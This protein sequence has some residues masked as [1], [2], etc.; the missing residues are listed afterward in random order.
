[1]AIGLTPSDASRL[2]QPSARWWFWW[3]LEGP[4]PTRIKLRL[5]MRRSS[6]RKCCMPKWFQERPQFWDLF[7][8]CWRFAH[9]KQMYRWQDRERELFGIDQSIALFKVMQNWLR[10]HRKVLY[11]SMVGRQRWSHGLGLGC[12][13]S[14][15]MWPVDFCCG[16]SPSIRVG[17]LSR[18]CLG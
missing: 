14:V 17:L 4:R 12:L 16:E 10:R 1:M 18:S 5:W 11:L 7:G 2:L 13:S 6:V 15:V 8:F 3:C 9:L